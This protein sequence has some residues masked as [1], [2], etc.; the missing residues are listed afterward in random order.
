MKTS[1]LR[2]AALAAFLAN[3]APAQVNSGSNGSDGA[4][5]PTSNL[6]IDMADHPDG[7]Y[8]YTSV[9]VAAG[10][11]IP[12]QNPESPVVN[13]VAESILP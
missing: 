8:H 12:F 2:A 5:N 7:I 11:D 9:N 13:L 3:V 6:V 4:L 10:G 1:V